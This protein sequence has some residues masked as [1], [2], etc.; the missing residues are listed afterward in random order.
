V[1]A[2]KWILRYLKGTKKLAIKYLAKSNNPQENTNL[3]HGYADT[4]YANMDDLKSTSSYVFIVGGGAITWRS[5]KQ[6]TVALYLWRLDML[7]YQRRAE[8]LAGFRVYMRSS[9]ILRDLQA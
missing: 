6:T 8:K 5:K 3:F 9:D 2:V 4:A 1:G 7:P